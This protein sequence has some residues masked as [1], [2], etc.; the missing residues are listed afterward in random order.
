[1]S[2][3]VVKQGE[4]EKLSRTVNILLVGDT[5]TKL[6]AL[7]SALADLGQ[8]LVR[9]RSWEEA[10]RALLAHDFAVILLDV[11]MSGMNGFELAKMLRSRPRSKHTPIIFISA[12][13]AP[14]T[15]PHAS[16]AVGAV[17]YIY[18]PDPEVL[19]A[20]V[21]V[22]VEL[23]QKT[24]AITR[25][26]ATIRQLNTELEQRVAARTAALQ[27]S[28]EALQ[29]FVY[30]ASHDLQEP[31]RTV[32]T[33]VKLLARRYQGKLDADTEEFIGFAVDGAERMQQLI[34]GLLAYSRVESKE[35]T[36]TATDCE[37]VLACTLR[38]LQ[39]AIRESEAEI[40]HDPLPTVA[41][42]AQQLRLV[43]QNLLGNAIKFRSSERPRIHVSA[44]QD[45]RQWR[46][47]VRDNGIGLDPRQAERIFHIFQRLHTRKEYPG[48]GIGLAIC[49]QVVERHG[50]RMWVE[51]APG[52]G[53]TFFFTLSNPSSLSRAR[54]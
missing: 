50:G 41:A 52:Q 34:Q 12:V 2:A 26:A 5:P 31:L 18:T 45:G 40:T 44:A 48:T 54:A 35:L 8:N 17:D 11:N 29:Q 30:V 4:I 25:Q 49:K 51:S 47:A 16:Y 28:N 37:S 22:F 33:Y 21:K 9:A 6:L 24:E 14:E 42:D 46:F 23:F 13:D 53:A 36:C 7:H 32:A 20:K 19:R 10:L 43:L 15:H 3:A 1:M 38:D 39:Q 27:R